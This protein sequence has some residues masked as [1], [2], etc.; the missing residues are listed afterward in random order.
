MKYQNK[1]VGQ[2]PSPDSYR[3]II[4]LSIFYVL[5]PWFHWDFCWLQAT[6]K[7]D[8]Q[9]PTRGGG[10]KQ[11]MVSPEIREKITHQLRLV[12]RLGPIFHRF[13]YKTHTVRIMDFW[14][15]N[16]KKHQTFTLRRIDGFPQP[17]FYGWK[18][19]EKFF[20]DVF[21]VESKPCTTFQIFQDRRFDDSNCSRLRAKIGTVASL[22][23]R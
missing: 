4:D 22:R 8:Q 15:I 9:R 20:V 16:R 3:Y 5:L 6:P 23:C 10:G 14:S 2:N 21:I 11:L 1:I 7:K 17:I 12:G 18:V 19:L 13:F